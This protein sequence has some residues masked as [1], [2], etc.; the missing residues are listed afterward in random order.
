V[1]V[2]EG[3]AGQYFTPR[4]LIQAIVD[5]NPIISLLSITVLEGT[6]PAFVHRDNKYQ[7]DIQEA[8]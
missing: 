4:A 3:D 7:R 8:H 5:V 2:K 1:D 6:R